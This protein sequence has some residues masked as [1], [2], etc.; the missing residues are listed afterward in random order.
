[1]ETAL[2]EKF[3]Q[4]RVGVHD[5]VEVVLGTNWGGAVANAPNQRIAQVFTST[6]ALGGYSHDDG[7][8]ALATVR[9]QLLRAAYFGTLLAAIALRKHTVVLTLIGGGA[10]GNPHR[11][12]W[13]AINW[14]IAEAEP[15]VHG[16]L[17]VVVNVRSD[18]VEVVDLA[19]A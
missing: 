13:D 18:A 5:D 8:H 12:I 9:G 2:E 10:F 17:D 19:R 15:H 4:L 6:I 16:V 7:S 11:S 3:G 14:A 1:M